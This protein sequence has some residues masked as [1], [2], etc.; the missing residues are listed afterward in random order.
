MDIISQSLVEMLL[1]RSISILGGVSKRWIRTSLILLILCISIIILVIYCVFTFFMKV[2]GLASHISPVL[3]YLLILNILLLLL[4]GIVFILSR[5]DLGIMYFSETWK[6]SSF[7]FKK[8]TI[9]SKSVWYLTTI[10][11]FLFKEAAMQ[12]VLAEKDDVRILFLD[13][14]STKFAIRMYT[15]RPAQQNMEEARERQLNHC[16]M[17]LR[18]PNA[19]IHVRW[20]NQSPQWRIVVF[21]H[22]YVALGWFPD[23]SKTPIGDEN[24][25]YNGPL[26][27]FD[28]ELA[29]RK[30][31]IKGS[32]KRALTFPIS[33]LG[34]AIIKY[35]ESVWEDSG[36]DLRFYENTS[37]I[38][39]ENKIASLKD[40]GI[41]KAW[42][43]EEK[44]PLTLLK[45]LR[46]PKPGFSF[47]KYLEI[48][49]NANDVDNIKS[50]ILVN[51]PNANPIDCF[52][53]LY[54]PRSEDFIKKIKA[55]GSLNPHL[56]QQ[57][58]ID[59]LMDAKQNGLI[60]NLEIKFL[61]F[62]PMYRYAILGYT[63]FRIMVYMGYYSLNKKGYESQ[64]WQIGGNNNPLLEFHLNQY[65]YLW[66]SASTF[67]VETFRQQRSKMNLMT[68]L[69]ETIPVS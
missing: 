63:D 56:R 58:F 69:N 62:P 4:L 29:K 37:H 49:A 45:L 39:E 51:N 43:S 46:E 34:T 10:G 57:T 15:E 32:G 3:P 24:K 35:F 20:H 2:G 36:E 26:I 47:Y 16:R 13:P 54:D 66:K 11:S 23:Y 5:L 28:T 18:I 33:T 22:R 65:E 68:F 8:M 27:V 55:E 19:N 42:S 12:Q 64:L 7:D 1:K 61:N 44:S 21:D 6:D 52:I 53:L 9:Q 25:G 50:Y 59:Q 40:L 17:L 31:S 41:I 60:R 48:S 67:D 14:S 30:V 38:Y